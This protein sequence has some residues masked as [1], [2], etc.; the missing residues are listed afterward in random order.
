MPEPRRVRESG[1]CSAVQL[2]RRLLRLRTLSGS[3]PGPSTS[4][5]RRIGPAEIRRWIVRRV[6]YTGQPGGSLSGGDWLQHAFSATTARPLPLRQNPALAEHPP[7]PH[8]ALHTP[9]AISTAERSIQILLGK[10]TYAIPYRSSHRRNTALARYL[11][12]CHA[13]QPHNALSRQP[14]A[15]RLS[16]LNNV[17]RNDN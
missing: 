15:E 16:Q 2:A 10:W 12:W 17:L 3:R 5:W 14:P 8:N 7:H 9:R 1:L 13:A 4:G 11:G 6:L